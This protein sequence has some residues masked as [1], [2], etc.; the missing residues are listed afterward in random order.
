V[1]LRQAQQERMELGALLVAERSEEILFDLPREGAHLSQRLLPLGRQADD[2]AAPVLGIAPAF[3]EPSV[4]QLV[5]EPDELAAVVPEPVGDR[6]LRFARALVHDEQ[7]RVVIGVKADL[8]VRG[9]RALL[10]REAEAFEEKRCRCHELGG[11]TRGPLY[12][13]G[14]RARCVHVKKSS[15]DN[16][17]TAITLSMSTIARKAGHRWSA[18]ALI[19]TAQFMVILDVAIVNVALPSIKSDLH[20]SETNL[21]WVISAYA[22]LFGGT[23]LLGGRLA[24]LLGRRK[25][26]VAGLAVFAV[27][28][29]L[30][31]LAWSEG[32]LITFRAVQGLGGAMLAPA[33]LS[34]LMTIFS[35]GRE[36]NVALGI[37]GAASGSGAAAGVLLG[38][39]LTS[40]LSWSWIFF[41]NVPVGIVAIALTPVLL[42]ESDAGLAH[43]HFDFPG[44]ASITAGLMLLVYT[45]TRATT[46]GWGSP[47]TLALLG[48]AVALVL[49]FVAIELRSPSP[50]LPLR[51]FRLRTLTAANVAMAI[52]GAVAFSEFFLLTLYL[53]DVLH[54][55]AVQ[56]G[57]AFAAFALSVVV[58]SNVAQAIVGRFGVRP[59]L[60]AGLLA[61]A[62]S[63]A[64]L[65]K[66]PVHGHYFW[67]LFPWFVLGGAGMGLSFVPV[68]IASLTGVERSE[69]GVASGLINT[70]RQIGGAIG[71]AAISAV[72]ATST[73]NY[74]QAHA[75]VTASSGIALAHGFQT[76]LYVLTALLILGAL[77]TV[78][79]VR[80]APAP[81][82][83][84]LPAEGDAVAM[85]EAA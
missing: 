41:I 8:L 11:E 84:A 58:M 47:T 72:A 43:R 13:G 65:T 77:I 78:A 67:D 74:V 17:W 16:G 85:D 5:E 73:S 34:L 14:L 15:A 82:A 10:R 18:L 23:L 76:G 51:I 56:S 81:S 38:G 55:S 64:L 27:S 12:L 30:C 69:A 2:V 50:L 40:Y 1:R 21:Q 3:D 9:Q 32:S 57:A 37:Y 79:L 53:Q 24:D 71:I 25:L 46:D 75:A 29:L 62:V 6:P 39:V 59:T 68:T 36:R 61:S 31:G 49:A 28:S 45:T 19:V 26:F 22:I 60:T 42:Q 35:E 44:A 63:V 7:D 54:Y 33:A 52:V 48:G 66:L 70:S 83:H 80:S 4:L 20:F